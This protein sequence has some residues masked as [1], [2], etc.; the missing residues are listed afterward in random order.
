VK[1]CIEKISGKLNHNCKLSET[2][3]VNEI[4]G[5]F[6]EYIRILD[7]MKSRKERTNEILEKTG[8]L[9]IFVSSCECEERA[10]ILSALQLISLAFCALIQRDMDVISAENPSWT[11]Q[12]R[13]QEVDNSLS[14]E[15]VNLKN[16]IAENNADASAQSLYFIYHLSKQAIESEN[17]PDKFAE[18]CEFMGG[19]MKG[20][21]A[22]YSK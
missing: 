22:I 8:S 4:L 12:L 20:L 13:V 19:F 14:T 17:L 5:E 9:R 1:S 10:E 18:S 11:R 16:S 15:V 6:T 7:L 2:P 21:T 3:F